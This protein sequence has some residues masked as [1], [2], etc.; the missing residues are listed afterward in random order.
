MECI[1]L[2]GSK[3]SIGSAIS[4]KLKKNGY[5][6][7]GIDINGA[8]SKDFIKFDLSKLKSEK[9]IQ[10]LSMLLNKKIKSDNCVGLINNAAIQKID[11][12]ESMKINDFKKSIDVN[13]LA[14]LVL[15]KILLDK[16]K[17]SHGN[18][19]NIGSIHSELT[20]PKFISY[21]TSKAGLK[22]L[23]K[24]MAVDAGGSI[25]VNMISPAAINTPMLLE[26]LNNDINKIEALNN[27]HP[28]KCIGNPDEVAFIV[29][30]ILNKNLKFM[31]G[32]IVNI[33][34]AISSRLYDP[35]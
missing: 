10:E 34:G 7:I 9:K 33:D 14:P 23:T 1:V 24:S 17:Q 30:S 4:Q 2:T 31:N 26:G 35:D 8:N 5:R 28:S 25:R 22:G 3:G 18:I 16:L 12:L 27:F 19:I 21:S 29:L 15:A 6:V 20:K 32:S 13:L 11:S